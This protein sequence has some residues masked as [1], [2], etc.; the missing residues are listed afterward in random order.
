M[1]RGIHL[2]LETVVVLSRDG[3]LYDLPVTA[4]LTCLNLQ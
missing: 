4:L 1:M 3:D 2:I